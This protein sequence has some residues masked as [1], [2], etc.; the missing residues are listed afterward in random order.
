[1]MREQQM[2][3]NNQDLDTDDLDEEMQGFEKQNKENREFLEGLRQ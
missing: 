3:E 2:T 1:M